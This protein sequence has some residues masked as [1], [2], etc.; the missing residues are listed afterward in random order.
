M[1]FADSK[2]QTQRDSEEEDDYMTFEQL[3]TDAVIKKGK[4]EKKDF[5]NA[6]KKVDN[7]N[8]SSSYPHQKHARRY[9]AYEPAPI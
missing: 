2:V 8:P 9:H 4:D 1:C 6:K 5:K 7:N 3:M